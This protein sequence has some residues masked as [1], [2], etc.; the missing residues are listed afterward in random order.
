MFESVVTSRCCGQAFIAVVSAE[1]NIMIAHLLHHFGHLP[2]VAEANS[3]Q[4]MDAAGESLLYY[5]FITV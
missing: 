4:R 5:E 1:L 2:Q 3:P